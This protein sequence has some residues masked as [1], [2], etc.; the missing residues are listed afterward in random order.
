MTFLESPPAPDLT[1]ARRLLNAGVKLVKLH[2]YTKQPIGIEWNRHSATSIDD[3]ATGYGIPLAV[4][5]LCSI[6]PDHA[7]MA[8][9]AMKAWGFDLEELLSAG[10]RTSSTRPDS[11]GRS[12]FLADPEG[13]ARW[14]PFRVFDGQ[15]RS[16]TVLELRAQSANLQDVVPGVVYA[17]KDTGELYSQQYANEHRFDAA[18]AVPEQFMAVWRLLSTNDDK[19]REHSRLAVEAIAAAGFKVNGDEPQYRPPMGGGVQLAFP[20]KGVRTEF[21]KAHTVDSILTRHGYTYHERKGRWAHPGATGAP[22][23]RPIPGKEGLW[24]S[25]HGGDPLHGT[26]DA[27]AAHVQLDHAGD[28]EAARAAWIWQGTDSGTKEVSSP[29]TAPLETMLKEIDRAEWESDE[30]IRLAKNLLRLVENLP[31]PNQLQWHKRI[32][33]KTPWTMQHLRECLKEFRAEWYGDEFDQLQLAGRIIGNIGSENILADGVGVWSWQSHGVWRLVEERALKQLVQ[34]Q[35]SSIVDQVNANTV[36]SVADLIKNEIYTGEHVWNRGNK[37]AVNCLNGELELSDDGWTLKPHCRENYSTVQVPVTYTPGAQCPRFEQF[38]GEVFDG[39]PDAAQKT[40]AI[41]EQMGYSLMRHCRYEF[42]LMLVGEG[43]NGKSVLMRL[44]E[45]LAGPKNVSGV[46]PDKFDSP[47]QRANLQNKLV[48]IITEMEKGTVIADA[49]V[50]AIT[51]G[52]TSTVE[53]KFGDPFEMAPYSTLWIG[54]NHIPHTR[55]F[56]HGLFRRMVVMS[57][58]NTF[59]ESLGNADPRLEEKLEAE[60]PGVLALC[61]DAYAR[62]VKHG[63]TIPDSTKALRQKWRLDADQVAQFVDEQCDT[64]VEYP[65]ANLYD[66]YR[67]WC[68]LSGIAKPLGKNHFGDRLDRLGYPSKRGTGGIRVR[69]GLTLRIGG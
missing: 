35:L 62:A 64:G 66:S 3:D 9:V 55:D 54:T 46:Q 39:D 45:K 37:E 34:R 16:L 18:P 51:S 24:Q 27:W 59:D 25:D 56:S 67:V 58:N 4:N 31:K 49:A 44:M 47:F 19:L 53:H 61:L 50:K 23:I 28:V 57:F 12:A 20:A 7:E 60:L 63:F 29:P 15:G 17:S 30:Q 5:G 40:Q 11:G 32:V 33:D 36:N 43:G 41:L 26:F 6:D 69:C 42:M 2:Y 68:Q 48:N 13:K 8:R 14:L 65:M 21:N 1:E 52:E 10:V 22:A 38:L